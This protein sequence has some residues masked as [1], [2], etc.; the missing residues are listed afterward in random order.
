MRF[1]RE[2]TVT[3]W[4]FRAANE[5]TDGSAPCPQFQAW[6]LNDSLFVLQNTTPNATDC[7]CNTSFQT[8]SETGVCTYSLQSPISVE[9][10][11]IL[12]VLF[13]LPKLD[14]EFKQG[15]NLS[16]RHLNTN[17]FAVVN[18]HDTAKTRYLP[19]IYPMIMAGSD[20]SELS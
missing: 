5:T 11:D 18:L 20:S 7:S 12:G 1:E 15:N 2:G 3:E 14:L 9:S 13:P 8:T 16:S 10:G 4:L 17:N 19:L 6:K